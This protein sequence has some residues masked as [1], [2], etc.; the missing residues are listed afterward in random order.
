MQRGWLRQ[1][2]RLALWLAVVGIAAFWGGRWLLSY[3]YPLE[4]REIIF[5]RAQEYGL[6]PYLVAAVIR[7]ESRFHADATSAQGARGLMQ[8]MPDTGQ[9]AAAQMQIPYSAD[10]L[11]DPDYNVRMGCW[12]LAELEKEF[13]DTVLVLAA[14]NGG[15]TNVAR[16]LEQRQWTGEH[17]TLSQIPFPE[18]RQ[19]VAAVMRNHQ[20]YRWIYASGSD[21]GEEVLDAAVRP[22]EG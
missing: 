5:Q 6:D 19:Y 12:Y 10:L 18:T 2:I 11:Y 17:Q 9:W 21:S 3:I 4:Y 22:T 13:G 20:W 1:L 14:Y 15:R 8:I 7:A 16:W